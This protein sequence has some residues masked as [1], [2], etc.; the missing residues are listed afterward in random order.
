MKGVES[1]PTSLGS[2]QN[3]TFYGKPNNGDITLNIN[4]GN[5]YL[6]G[7]PYPSALDANQFIIDNDETLGGTGSSTGTLYFW[8]H[9]GGGSHV[10][11]EYKGGYAS[12]TLSG[13]SPA[14]FMGIPPPGL[15]KRPGR[16][17]PVAQAFFVTAETTG[18]IK[19]NNGQRVFQNENGITSLFVKPGSIK[20]T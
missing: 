17:I 6:I 8:Q 5:D 9:W 1:S 12:Y 16:F 2:T 11:A 18:T 3:Y 10:L 19:F 4:E 13:G 20:R 15:I 14:P 7:N